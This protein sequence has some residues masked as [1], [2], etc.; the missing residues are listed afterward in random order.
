[1]SLGRHKRRW[2]MVLKYV[3]DIQSTKIRSGFYWLRT[4][5]SRGMCDDGKEY[6][7]FICAEHFFRTCV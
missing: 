3:L 6:L 1:M 7:G 4:R 2:G 5:S